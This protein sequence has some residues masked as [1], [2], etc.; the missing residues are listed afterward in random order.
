MTDEKYNPYREQK[1]KIEHEVYFEPTIRKMNQLIEE[2]DLPEKLDEP[3]VTV[4]SEAYKKALKNLEQT[5]KTVAEERKKNFENI[6]G[7]KPTI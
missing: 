7:R 2:N 6:I 3:S 1:A 4:M 5:L